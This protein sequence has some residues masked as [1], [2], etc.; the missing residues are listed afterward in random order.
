MAG[1]TAPTADQGQALWDQVNEER[2]AGLPPSDEPK[3]TESEAETHEAAVDDA[4][5]A[6]QKQPEP[7]EDPYAGMSPALRA[8]FE[9]LEARAAQAEQIPQLFQHVKTAEGRVA[10]IQ[11]ELDS[12]KAAAKATGNGPSQAQIQAAAQSTDKWDSLRADFPEWADATEQFVKASLQGVSAKQVEGLTPAQVEAMVGERL[13]AERAA[14]QRAIEEAKV[15]GKYGDWKAVINTP[16]FVDW[17]SKQAAD[18]KALGAS[19]AGRDAIR[20]L[21]TYHAAVAAPAAVVQ[22][23]RQA[24]LAAAVN[25]RPSASAPV[26][27]TVD[28]MSPKELWEHERKLA[29]KRNNGRHY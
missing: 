7:E 24:K 29:A 27:K 26:A 1:D 2:E 10:A 14:T 12:A 18:V 9:A 19:D 8:R 6:T 21:D 22:E 17:Y 16:Q 15:E 20:L 28:Q 3:S 13:T 4:Q 11:R 25:T 5:T 23:S